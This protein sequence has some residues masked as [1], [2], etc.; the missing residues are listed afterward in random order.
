MK[1]VFTLLFC[2]ASLQLVAQEET[3]FGDLSVVGAFGGP[4]IEIGSINGEVV[5]DVGGGG[6]LILNNVFFGGYG[7][8][9]DFASARIDQI[10]YDIR[11][12][13]GGLW[14]GVTQNEHKLTH[15][16]S[17]LRVGWGRARLQR[18]GETEFRDRLFVL[19]PEV[20]VEFNITSFFKVG[21]TGGYRWVN[22][23]NK[24]PTL[25]NGDFS[26]PIGTI[27]FRFGGFENDWDWDW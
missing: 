5:A 20:G 9:T 11:F 7:L 14:F 26:S 6:A 16:Y 3:L 19:T 27:T 17:S 13:H 21:L 10:D 2:L 15:F 24:L 12:S 1:N 4:L 23:I 18:D 25:E 22:G 8:G